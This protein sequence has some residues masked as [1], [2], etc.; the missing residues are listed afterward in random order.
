MGL[1][2]R[3]SRA[4]VFS[5][6]AAA[7]VVS[8]ASPAVAQS[9]ADRE[10]AR[11]RMEEGE[12]RRERGDLRGALRMFEEADA[13][14]RVPTTGLEVARTQVQLNLLLEA[15]ETLARVKAIPAKA[16]EPAAF[17]QARKAADQLIT[18]LGPRIPTLSVVL[19]NAD[20]AT[21]PRLTIDG[22]SV[23]LNVA[24]S[25]RKVNPGTHLI[26][27][28]AGNI[29]KKDE[30][31]LVEG[32]TKSVTIDLGGAPAA[33]TGS[34][35]SGTSSS[36]SSS[37][38]SGDTGEKHG[39]RPSGG[40]GTSK[41]LVYGGFAVGVIGIGVGAVTGLMSFSKVSDLH[42]KCGGDMCPPQYKS[43]VD[44]AKDLGTIS[45]ISFIVGGAGVAAGVVGLLVPFGGEEKAAAGTDAKV[46][47]R[48]NVGLGFVGFDGRF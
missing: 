3:S 8:S 39:D 10:T 13:I 19:K 40:G 28:S 37:S 32:Q 24:E 5:L 15:K 4:F 1:L 11:N 47:V 21:P 46:R 43:D 30:A 6:C 7:A 20:P 26:V 22:E 23:P 27:V 31:K 16:G 42:E 35:S 34:G 9:A 17:A 2:S 44:G 36:G 12:S 25:G 45:T 14:M 29:E 38:S 18:D 33:S 41:G 48:P